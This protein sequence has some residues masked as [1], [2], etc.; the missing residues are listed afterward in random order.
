MLIVIRIGTLS[1]EPDTNPCISFSEATFASIKQHL[2]L[3]DVF[4]GH[5]ISI[6]THA[7]RYSLENT[8]KKVEHGILPPF[9]M[10][11]LKVCHSNSTEGFVFKLPS[12]LYTNL[13]RLFYQYAILHNSESKS[14]HGI[15]I[16]KSTPHVVPQIL[17]ALQAQ[18][19]FCD[20]AALLPIVTSELFIVFSQERLRDVENKLKELEESMGQH[21]Y[22]N[23]P[24][25]NPLEI[26]FLATTR[27]L[28][29]VSK[30]VGKDE[31]RMTCMLRILG[32]IREFKREAD[33]AD[34][35]EGSRIMD[36]KLD[37]LEDSCRA[38]F[39]VCT[40]QQ[41]RISTLLQVVCFSRLF[42]A[43]HLFGA[44]YASSRSINSWPRR[45][46]KST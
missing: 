9:H 44:N 3:P 33:G 2:R 1:H 22:K 21:E 4:L 19:E 25:G 27:K 26:D 37:Y 11:D 38:M 24:R 45:T 41:K 31:S 40:Y 7:Y 8:G 32:K 36:E 35:D 16:S 39:P 42:L 10:H 23:R 5:I 15:I 6:I 43:I 17:E 13:G 18:A 46:P 12:E 28:N 30:K 20:Q 34:C 29:Y 14:T